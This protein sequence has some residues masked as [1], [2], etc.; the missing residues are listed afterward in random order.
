MREAIT[1]MMAER[2]YEGRGVHSPNA[3]GRLQGELRS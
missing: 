3:A 2:N 1:L